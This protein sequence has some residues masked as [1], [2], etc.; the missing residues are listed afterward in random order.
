[1]SADLNK[2]RPSFVVHQLCGVPDLLA[3]LYLMALSLAFLAPFH[4]WGP[5]ALFGMLA[6]PTLWSR[7]RMRLQQVGIGCQPLPRSVL[8]PPLGGFVLL[9]AAW[10]GIF[11]LLFKGP[12]PEALQDH[13]AVTSAFGWVLGPTGLLAAFSLRWLR[14]AGYSLFL[15]AV[16][17][18]VF[19]GLPAG[20][21]FLATG[22][23]MAACGFYSF[24]R[25][26]RRHPD[27]M[28]PQALRA[29]R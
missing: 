21:P 6:F 1:M 7:F 22:L 26:L 3:G 18:A 17:A 9:L 8:V 25:Y 2:P 20:V 15:L 13:P 12:V 29:S 10:T 19:L 11:L 28:G 23:L 16:N 4:V 5:A 14:W 27:L 24:R